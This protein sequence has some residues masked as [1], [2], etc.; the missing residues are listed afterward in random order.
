M[1]KIASAQLRAGTRLALVALLTIGAGCGVF[2]RGSGGTPKPAPTQTPPSG[3]AVTPPVPA[4]SA[5]PPAPVRDSA[6]RPDS[7]ARADS[8]ARATAAAAEE[9]ARIKLIR[10]STARADSLTRAAEAKKKAKPA[11]RPCVMDFADSPPETRLLYSRV[12][13]SIS[14]TFIGGG[15]VGHCQ[16]ENNR[17]RA[18]SAE[19]FQA[20]GIV[21]LYGNVMYEEPGKV[22]IIASHAT[23][24]TRE[25]RLYADGN[26]TA[27]QLGT[28]S[29]F[30]GPAIEYYR[31]MPDRPVSRMIAPTRSTARVI[32]K[33]SLGR[34]SPPTVI[35]ANRFE[36]AGDSLLMAWGDVVIDRD[37]LNGRSD[38]A[39]FDK[40][41]EKARL[42]RGARVTNRDTA[43]RFTLVGDTIDMYS[44][45]RELDR[46]V[47]LHKSSATNDDMVLDAERIDLRLETRLLKEAFAFGPG[48]A[49]AHTPQQDV[50]ADSLRIRLEDKR[51]R[52][53][54]AVGGAVAI[55]TPDSLRIKTTE[56][57]VL[58]GDKVF[59][60][61]DS[62][63]RVGADTARKTQIN[64]IRAMGNASSLFHMANSRGR[65]APPGINY[66]R[67]A[68][69]FVNFDTG[70]VRT[71]RVD[72]AASGLYLEPEAD[73]LSDSTRKPPA[74]GKPPG[75]PPD[76]T[77]KLPP[78]RPAVPPGKRDPAHAGL[79]LSFLPPQRL[80]APQRYP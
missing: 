22:Q 50:E 70:A 80:T 5:R 63:P 21:N 19:Q 1:S 45:N 25:G 46:V 15:F 53:V 73:S 43:Q 51:V 61:F 62:T 8:I 64:E 72:S 48:R 32:E 58:R 54:H 6:A 16:G 71:V 41:K 37:Q 33:D 38:S 42:V 24:F 27:T 4:D 68:R 76:T 9:A 52:E 2:S 10:D 11:S 39:S 78:G 56:K 75:A 26:V 66:V 12:T 20:P 14:N 18:D 59:A 34:N 47:A 7:A 77:A 69:I 79:S 23:Y 65:E 49:K 17:I 30:S 28:G 55:G 13:D 67:G 57:D 29:S 3:V 40:I 60:Y 31:A 36:D 44:T 74:K 35:V